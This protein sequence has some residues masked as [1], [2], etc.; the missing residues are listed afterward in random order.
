MVF[1]ISI[2]SVLDIKSLVLLFVSENVLV[3]QLNKLQNHLLIFINVR[4]T[5]KSVFTNVL[6]H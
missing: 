2:M 4:N 6:I 1:L 5:T 3:N